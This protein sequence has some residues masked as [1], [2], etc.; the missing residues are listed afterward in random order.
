MQKLSKDMTEKKTERRGVL[1]SPSGRVG[2]L[3]GDED[4]EKKSA[5]CCYVIEVIMTMG[6]SPHRH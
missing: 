6:L 3:R 4:E 5:G 1:S 2:G